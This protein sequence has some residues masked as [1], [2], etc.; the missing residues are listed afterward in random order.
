MAVFGKRGF[1]FGDVVALVGAH[2]CGANL[3]YFPFD[4][5]PGILDSTTYY[6]E[7]MIGRA[8][9]ILQS[10]KNLALSPLTTNYWQ[11]YARDQE[12]WAY[13]YVRA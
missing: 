11:Q 3:S 6:T 12:V 4:T 7:V 1:A 5:T 9:A 2:S 10:D 13:D 8:P